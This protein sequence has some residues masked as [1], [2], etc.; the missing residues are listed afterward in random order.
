[1][2]VDDVEEHGEPLPVGGVDQRLE[3]ERAAVGGLRG[4]QVDAVVAPAVAAGE[5]AD[6]HQL[7]RGDP[8]LAQLAQ[9]RDDGLERAL[10]REGADVQLV[11]H[12]VSDAGRQPLPVGPLERFGVEQ[13]RRA[14]Q[15][16]GLP[17]AGRI[18]QRS[19]VEHEHVVGARGGVHDR[20]VDAESRVLHRVL[21]PVDAQA[22]LARMR[23][24]DAK[25]RAATRQR[26][27]AEGALE[28]QGVGCHLVVRLVTVGP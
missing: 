23:G 4:G 3:A 10:G 28:R 19:A 12:E 1:M 2:V 22:H 25:L 24:P 13:P 11:E 15:A 21:L 5:L 20:L 6:W 14:A 9:V 18:G 8:Q 16:L 26:M 17:A 27:G 7:D